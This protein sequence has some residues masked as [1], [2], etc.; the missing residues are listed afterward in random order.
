[1]QVI[2]FHLLNHVVEGISK[3]GPV[4]GTWMY[5]FERFNSWMCQRVLNRANP[6]TTVIQTYRVCI[7]YTMHGTY[8]CLKQPPIATGPATLG[9]WLRLHYSNPHGPLPTYTD[10]ASKYFGTDKEVAPLQKWPHS[11]LNCVYRTIGAIELINLT[12]LQLLQWGYTSTGCLF[13]S[14]HA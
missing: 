11:G 7:L 14:M 4:Y 6:E 8:S 5:S 3:L 10:I 13:T 12:L 2:T 9:R 1:M